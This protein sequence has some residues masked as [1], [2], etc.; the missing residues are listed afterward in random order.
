MNVDNQALPS[1]PPSRLVANTSSVL[2]P[3][4]VVEDVQAV[5][6]LSDN[7]LLPSADLS[8]P[9]C[10]RLQT[11]VPTPLPA[12]VSSKEGKAY[13]EGGGGKQI[14][15]YSLDGW[16]TVQMFKLQGATCSG[17]LI[18]DTTLSFSS[19]CAGANPSLN[20]CRGV[21]GVA[22]LNGAVGNDFEMGDR[23]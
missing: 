17:Q 14:P 15:V 18:P 2:R 3:W 12:G 5:R 11:P 10:T 19:A 6:N 9:G 22:E 1:V 13:I 7:A 8:N 4:A 23:L 20:W 21:P 16:K